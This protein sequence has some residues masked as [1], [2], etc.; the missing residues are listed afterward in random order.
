MGNSIDR[1]D[2]QVFHEKDMDADKAN[3][4]SEYR[5][6]AL[7]YCNIPNGGDSA[8]TAAA[9]RIDGIEIDV[10]DEHG[11]TALFWAVHNG[12]LLSA[13]L[14]IDAGA[15]MELTDKTGKVLL[16]HAIDENMRELV[17]NPVELASKIISEHSED[18]AAKS[19]SLTKMGAPTIKTSSH[20]LRAIYLVKTTTKTS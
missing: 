19:A 12:H 1:H 14:L 17:R 16:D 4:Q 6:T 11:T 5:E 2:N 18:L 13:A 9:L 7:H 10:I 3:C 20:V 8:C 15:D